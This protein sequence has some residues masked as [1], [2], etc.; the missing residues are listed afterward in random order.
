M[1]LSL[2]LAALGVAFA[3]PAAS[4][5]STELTT[6]RVASGLSRPVMA[7]SAPGETDRLFV[8]EQN[9]ADIHIVDLN[10]NTVLPTPFLDLTGLVTTS[11]NEQGL[12]GFTFHPDYASNG[13]FYVIYT[14][15]GGG[16]LRVVQYNV[17]GNPNIA[18]ANSAV[19]VIQVNQPQSNHNAGDVTFGPDGMMWIPTGDGGGANDSGSG[20]ASGGNGQ[21]GST[22]LGKMLRIDVSTLPYTIPADNPYAAAG[23]GVLDEIWAFG[24]RNPFR[25]SF[26]SETGDLWIGD[27]GQN[28]R[29][30]VSFASAED[31]AAVAAD[32][33]DPFNFGWRCTE[34]FLCTG[35]SGCTC[36][37]PELTNPLDAYAHNQGLSVI[38]GQ[39]YHGLAIPDLDGMYVFADHYTDIILGTREENSLQLPGFPVNLEG[40]L[41]PGGGLNLDSI[42]GFGTDGDG[43]I[44]FTDLNGG[45]VFKIVPEGPYTG[46]GCELAGTEGDP[47]HF[48]DGGVAS[49]EAGGLYLRN[50]AADATA[51]L[52]YSLSEGATPF[53]GGVLKTIPLV[54]II[55]LTTDGNGELDLTWSDTGGAPPGTE[56]VTQFGI[57]DDGAIKGVALSNALLTTWP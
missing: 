9:Q 33:K 19:T 12:L 18:D 22:L 31:I 34:G 39:V 47:I 13:K 45:E 36:G 15:S 48:G 7:T 55:I 49:G 56:L 27:V 37:G 40:Q 42:A 21:S 20:H 16:H 6:V 24:L 26:D 57:D 38:G 28:A 2:V 8:A 25:V 52:F 43:E 46:L 11:G 14:A 17:S 32:T 1:R 10:T 23:D 4:G 54:D 35:L 44:Y 29:E 5:Q 41:A 51:G 50:A 3:T 30:E 53:K